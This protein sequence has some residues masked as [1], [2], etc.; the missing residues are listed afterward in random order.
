MISCRAGEITAGV[1]WKRSA[2][3]LLC[4][5]SLFI[6]QGATASASPGINVDATS[7]NGKS[8]N[9]AI[10]DLS[11]THTTGSGFN[12]ALVVGVSTYSSVGFPAARVQSVNYGGAALQAVGVSIEPTSLTSPPGSFSATEMFILIAP[13]TGDATITVTFNPAAVVTQTVGGAVSFTGVNQC[14]PAGTFASASGSTGN[15][16]V[17]VASASDEVVVDTVATNPSAG[18]LATAAGQAERWN[19][20]VHFFFAYS[21]G[22]G[23]TKPG[24]SPNVT[25]SWAQTSPQPWAIGAISLKPAPVI[26]AFDFDADLRTDVSVWRPSDGKWFINQS[27]DNSQRIQAWGLNTLGDKPV[28]ADYDG[29]GK[30]DIAI[31]RAGEGNWYIIKSSDGGLLLY[32]WGAGS[33]G[34]KPVPADY[35]GDGKADV[36]VFRPGEGNW[37]IRNS[38]NGSV[39]VRGWG[40]STDKLVPAD[41]D[42]DHKTDIAVWRP[43][44]GNWYIIN[45]STNAVT[46]RQWGAST[47]Q[48]VPG[49]YCGDGKADIAVWRPSDGNWFI[50]N[51]CHNTS[52]VRGW[53]A[54]S[55]G[56]VPVPGDYDGD[57]RI[58]IA[59]WR[60]SE[61]NWYI[62]NSSTGTISLRSLGTSGDVPIPS[63]YFSG[64]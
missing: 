16:T 49:D 10:T 47:D 25:M 39:T 11:W 19:G 60:A 61:G 44:E 53:G 46:I 54:G 37:Y 28:P 51:S 8:D 22:A 33:L 29:D 3:G 64:N 52:T 38:S 34:D 9:V 12:R 50:I 32:G 31:W 57:G 14:T 5:I 2:F 15:P 41:Y 42:G 45:S 17:F 13:P 58:D 18:S 55:L 20:N 35:D 62:I 48:P 4:A 24:A 6:F 40:A 27:S 23:S 1:C 63:V 30:T 21:L 36:A 26:K 7:S 43:S 56:D 59:V